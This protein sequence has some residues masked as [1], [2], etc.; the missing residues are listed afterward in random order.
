MIQV[1]PEGLVGGLL[2][3]RTGIADG[4]GSGRYVGSGLGS[5]S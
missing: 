5:G 3:G 2:L 1:G 4:L